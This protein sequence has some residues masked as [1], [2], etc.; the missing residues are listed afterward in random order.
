LNLPTHEAH[1]ARPGCNVAAE[2]DIDM[3]LLYAA[4]QDDIHL[5]DDI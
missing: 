4:K 2:K 1:G 3:W 5:F